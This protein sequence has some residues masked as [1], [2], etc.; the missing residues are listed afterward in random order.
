MSS[1][2]HLICISG[3]CRTGSTALTNLFGIAG[4]PAFYQPVKTILRRRVLDEPG[5]AWDLPRSDAAEVVANK[6]MTGPYTLAECLFNPIQLLLEAGYPRERLHLLLL[7]RDPY[8]CLA[9]WRDKWSDRLGPD[10]LLRNF[11]LASVN[12]E[13]LR[14]YAGSNGV[15]VL[16]YVYGLARWPHEAISALFSRLGISER[17]NAA[18]VDDWGARGAIESDRSPVI[19][20]EEPEPYRIV[21]LHSS[22]SQYRFRDRAT[23]ALSASDRALIEDCGLT[24]SY[25]RSLECSC[26]DLLLPDRTREQ[27]LSWAP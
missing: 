1:F 11:A 12:A 9:S 22:D 2:P 5:D 19:F 14:D 7:D 20:P 27:L 25:R 23:G 15:D 18:V 16:T 21:G 13:R 10:E 3:K 24:D 6:E 17:F 4:V 26:S 8:E